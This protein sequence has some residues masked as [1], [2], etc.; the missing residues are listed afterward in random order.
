MQGEDA[1]RGRL[2]DG[3]QVA[4][5]S[6]RPAGGRALGEVRVERLVA[7]GVLGPAEVE[8]AR[9]GQDGAVA[10]QPGRQHAVEHVHSPGH[11]LDDPDRVAQAHHVVGP[12]GGQEGNAGVQGGQHLGPLLP[13]R[14]PAHRVAVEADLHGALG[15]FGPQLLVDAAL[16]DAELALA[17]SGVGVGEEG[18]AGPAGPGGRAVGR[19]GDDGP[20]GAGVRAHVKDHGDVGA[21]Q[22]L[23]LDGPLRGEHAGGAVVDG[24]EPGPV[25]VHL[26]AQREDLV[27]ARVGEHVPGPVGEAVDAA[28]A[29]HGLGAGPQHQVIG[30]GQHHL[31]AQ[32]LQVG[33]TQMGHR[34]P[35]A[36][37]H[38]ARRGERPPG[39]DHPAGSGPGL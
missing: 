39:G 7:A 26:R 15:R 17:G 35:G 6:P 19:L 10:G 23:D 37:R 20:L 28:E 14:Q 38:E 1:G 4:Q 3:Q 2:A 34:P 32:R 33:R 11:R 16:H 31:D 36:D 18:A 29:G 13:H 9:V 8:P 25:V 22:G 30:V 21:D 24:G 27:A 5:V 12:V